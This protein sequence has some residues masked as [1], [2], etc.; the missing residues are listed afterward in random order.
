MTC[1]SE[2]DDAALQ[3]GNQLAIDRRAGDAQRRCGMLQ[4]LRS[5]NLIR[6]GKCNPWGR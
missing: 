2:F 5:L 6:A 1:L 4:R 3:P